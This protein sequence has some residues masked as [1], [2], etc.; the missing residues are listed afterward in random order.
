MIRER[1]DKTLHL[2]R[3]EMGA[4]AARRQAVLAAT[5][6][7]CCWNPRSQGHLTLCRY[8]TD[9]D[10]M[11]AERDRRDAEAEVQDLEEKYRDAEDDLERAQDMLDETETALNRARSSLEEFET[12]V[13]DLEKTDA[14]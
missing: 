11:E 5:L 10:L 6:Y 1:T 14:A 3:Q 9:I 2:Y 8:A 7:P 13:N 12:R 4:D